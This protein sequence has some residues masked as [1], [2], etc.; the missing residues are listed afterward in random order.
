MRG[1][2]ASCGGELVERLGDVECA[3]CGMR[4]MRR[5]GAAA[6]VRRDPAAAPW[7]PPSTFSRA[8][9]PPQ[10]PETP[11]EATAAV[12]QLGL[13]SGGMYRPRL[14]EVGSAWLATEKWIF[15]TAFFLGNIFVTYAFLN[16][17]GPQGAQGIGFASV[18]LY[19]AI[20][21]ALAAFVVYSHGASIKN[22]CLL[23][24]VIMALFG[25]Y[26]IYR[27]ATA[28][29]DHRV[30]LGGLILQTMLYGW[31]AAILMRENELE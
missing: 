26:S 14:R 17:A 7:D 18:A 30:L 25:A 4:I 2:C 23:G 15:L 8:V 27:A 21:T 12:E 24:V 3:K 31:L 5:E 19:V 22:G 16:S 28:G 11:P 10:G 1:I 13:Y 9:A 6:S 20:P 29:P